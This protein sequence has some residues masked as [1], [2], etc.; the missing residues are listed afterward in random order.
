MGNFYFR[1]RSSGNSH[2][3]RV[4]SDLFHTGSVLVE[5]NLQAEINWPPGNN[6][7][8]LQ[9]TKENAILLHV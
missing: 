3:E 1:S 7:I 6:L 2:F 4:V 8:E 5:C 9:K